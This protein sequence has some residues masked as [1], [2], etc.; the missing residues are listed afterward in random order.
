MVFAASPEFQAVPDTLM[1]ECYDAHNHTMM[2]PS[3]NVCH[4]VCSHCQAASVQLKPELDAELAWWTHTSKCVVN[5]RDSFSSEYSYAEVQTCSYPRQNPLES[6]IDSVMTLYPP[7][8]F[9]LEPSKNLPNTRS[10]STRS[11]STR[12]CSTRS[13]S[14][15]SCSCLPSVS[16]SFLLLCYHRH[17]CFV[18][19][20]SS[21][22]FHTTSISQR[23]H[24]N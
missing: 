6:S 21:V 14:T 3:N 20:F 2:I 1:C 4:W 18:N 24:S 22:P 7:C 19:V 8:L 9:S 16:K 10:Y 11:C 23:G 12:S 17:H 15:R 13:C 5:G